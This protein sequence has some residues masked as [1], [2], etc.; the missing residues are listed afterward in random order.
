MRLNSFRMSILPFYYPVVLHSTDTFCL[1]PS[2]S[3][4]LDYFQ[5]LAIRNKATLNVFIWKYSC[6]WFHFGGKYE[7]ELGDLYAMY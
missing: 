4:H 3:G 7:V 5:N 1:S 2:V 6:T